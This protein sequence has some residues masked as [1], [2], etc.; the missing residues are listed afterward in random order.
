M[1]SNEQTKLTSKVVTDS[2][3]ETRMTALGRLR[4]EGIERKGKRTHAHGQQCGDCGGGRR[5]TCGG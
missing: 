5:G 1:E 4:G 2:S 3:I